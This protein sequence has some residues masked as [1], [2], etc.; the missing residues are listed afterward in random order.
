MEAQLDRVLGQ[1]FRHPDNQRLA[2]HLRHEQPH[3]FTFR[4]CPGLHATNNFAERAIRLKAMTRKNVGRQSYSE[5]RA[6]RSRFWPA[7]CA[8]AGS[9]GKRGRRPVGEGYYILR[10]RSCRRSFPPNRH[11]E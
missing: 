3:L 1:H 5:Q 7:F 6:Q 10:I 2:K 4:R 8:P 9:M 11:P